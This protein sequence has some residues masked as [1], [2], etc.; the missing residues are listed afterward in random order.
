MDASVIESGDKFED[1]IFEAL[2]DSDEIFVLF[3]PW[4]IERLYV[5]MEIGA[6]IAFKKRVVIVLYG[7]TKEEIALNPKMPDSVKSR[8]II[9]INEL[10]KYF[11]QLRERII[12]KNK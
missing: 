10:E 5:W 3:T 1:E 7:I 2:P 4:S 9:E 8:D 12:S 6:G 11:G